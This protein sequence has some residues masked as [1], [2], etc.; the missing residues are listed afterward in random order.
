[1]RRPA[2]LNSIEIHGAKN[3]RKSFFDPLL[4]PLLDESRNASTTLGDVLE[5]IKALNAKLDRFGGSPPIT[6]PEQRRLTGPGKQTS[7]SRS[8]QYI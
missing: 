7:S 3:T 2:T 4:R 6:A 5:G 8:Q 1:M